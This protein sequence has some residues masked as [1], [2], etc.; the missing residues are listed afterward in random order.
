MDR[1]RSHRCL[2]VFL[3]MLAMLA[4][5]ASCGCTVIRNEFRTVVSE[6]FKFGDNVDIVRTTERNKK[7][8]KSAYGQYTADHPESASSPDFR[9][10]FIEGFADYLTFGGDGAPPVVPPRRH[11][12]PAGQNSGRSRCCA[13]VVRGIRGWS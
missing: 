10:G 11:L 4:V 3:C 2:Q 8:A 1:R 5:S 7:L 9:D 13:R 12:E 6:P